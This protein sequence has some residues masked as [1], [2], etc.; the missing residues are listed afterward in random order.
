MIERVSKQGYAG[1]M[2]EQLLQPMKMF[3][4]GLVDDQHTRERLATGY[5]TDGKTP[6]PY[7]HMILGIGRINDLFSKYQPFLPSQS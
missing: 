7:C 4:A 1:F 5:G 6:I 3:T 2:T